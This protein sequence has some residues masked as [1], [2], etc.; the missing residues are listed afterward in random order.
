M[1]SS[2]LIMMFVLALLILM[3]A[4]FSATETAFSTFNKIRMKNMAAEGN[5]KAALV[6]NISK[7]Y[8]K[9][10]STI[11]IGNN[12]VNITSASLATVLFT[13]HFGD[14]GVT[15]STVVMTILVLIFGEI[16]PKSMAKESPEKFSIFSAPIL[17]FFIYLLTP[18][19]FVFSQWKRLL[20]KFFKSSDGPSI[21]D[22]ELKTIVDEAQNEGVL[23]E[24]ESELIRSAIEFDDLSAGDIAIP[25][26]DI[27]A[28]DLETPLDEIEQL[29]STTGYSRHPVYIKSIDNIVGMIHE[30]DFHSLINHGITSIQGIVADVVYAS[31][32]MKI[33]TLLRLLQKSKTHMAI[34]ADEFG[35]TFGL[36]TLEDILEEL[37]GDIWD[38]HDQIVEV[39]KPLDEHT[40]LVSCH[41]NLIDMFEYFNIQFQNKDLDSNTVNGWVVD[42]LG[43]IPKVGDTFTYE[44]LAVTITKASLKCVLEIKIVRLEETETDS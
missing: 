33:S 44:N 18:L 28:I 24:H 36:V 35:G 26:V 11:L 40:T 34:V 3:S 27:T 4:Y 5:K 31:E 21:T 39:F 6:L 43:H 1:D 32:N 22:E 25:R 17:N 20:S 38:E 23:D 15:I 29:F 16:S 9:M 7:D 41:A 19:T 13:R 12:I 14:L 2:S 10:L 30:K 8:D 42:L 37:V